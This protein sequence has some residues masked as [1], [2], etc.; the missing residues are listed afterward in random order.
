MF[1]WLDYQKK[2]GF[3]LLVLIGIIIVESCSNRDLKNNNAQNGNTEKTS[4][5][6]VYKNRDRRLDTIRDRGKLVCGVN[7]QL[8]G[9]SISN[10]RGEYFGMDVD[11]C[12]ALAAALFG[13]PQKVEYRDISAQERFQAVKLGEVDLLSRNTTWTMSRDTS[14][15]MEFAP[16]TFYDSQGLLVTKA[17]GINQ[18]DDLEGKSICVIS[19]T[20]NEQNLAEQMRRLSLNYSP[21]IFEDLDLLYDAYDQGNCKAVTGDL[22]QLTSR[23]TTLNQPDDHRVLD[24]VISKEPLG[25]LVANGEPRWFDVVKWV[26]YAMIQ[27]EQ[28]G[29]SS[30]N[31]DSFAQTSDS[32]IKRFLGMEGNLGEAINL[33]PDFA[34]KI[35]KYVGNYGEVYDRNIGEPFG[36]ERGLNALAIDGG[37]IYSPPF[38]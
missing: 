21:A 25:A 17:S 1:D 37:L 23:R 18:L 16:T 11:L 19:G 33:P 31:I 35:V 32:K 8:P 27:A 36:L 34:K 15:G 26:T 5:Q 3:L 2:I 24:V 10:D 6:S 14:M 30:K 20:T 38:R 12:R 28:L 9:F 4:K 13:D 29:I 7:G 22:S